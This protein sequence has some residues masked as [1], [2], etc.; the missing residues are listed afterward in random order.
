M[1]APA[2]SSVAQL[3]GV[4]MIGPL[5]DGVFLA[6]TL[7]MTATAVLQEK[8]ACPK[9]M[10][11]VEGDYCQHAEQLCLRWNDPF[12]QPPLQCA[13]FAPTRPCRFRQDHKHFCID[14][15]EWPN[16]PGELPAYSLTW[17]TARD[18]CAAVGKRLCNDDEW[19]LAC[20]GQERWPYLRVLPQQ[21]GLQHRQVLPD[22]R[23]RTVHPPP[24]ARRSSRS[25]TSASPPALARR[26]S[27]RSGSTT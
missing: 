25:S 20:E 9:D 23:P 17:Y 18:S 2:G 15:Y 14:R 26:A 8:A 24:H 21:G 13:E 3:R 10:V 1:D 5:N 4:A 19:T 16:K 11:D 6:N 27:A 12:A 22:A 7:K